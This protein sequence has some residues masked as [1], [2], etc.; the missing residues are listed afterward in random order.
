MN[1]TDFLIALIKEYKVADPIFTSELVDAFIAD[2]PWENKAVL[3]RKKISAL[4]SRLLKKIQKNNLIPTLRFYKKGTWYTTKATV[5]GELPIKTSKL[6]QK[7]YLDGDNG[8]ITGHYAVY[9]YGLSTQIPAKIIIATNKAK[10]YKQDNTELGVTI[11]PPKIKITKSNKYYLQLLDMLEILNKAIVTEPNPY[12][13]FIK[14]IDT[15]N[16]KYEVLLKLAL[17][18]YPKHVIYQIAK[19]A[20]HTTENL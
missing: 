12:S 2:Y 7:K 3:D 13:F 1:H 4:V 20:E 14:Y 17:Q 6:I 16:L 19:I 18:Y 15:H 5:F 11:R 8:Y 10:K 9:R